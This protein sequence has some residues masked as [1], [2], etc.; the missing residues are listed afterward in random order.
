MDLVG[1][2]GLFYTAHLIID[3]HPAQHQ[4]P[5]YAGGD[6]FSPLRDGHLPKYART[7]Y[8]FYSL[9]GNPPAGNDCIAPVLKEELYLMP[10]FFLN[11]ASWS[12]R[13]DNSPVERAKIDLVIS[14]TYFAEPL[15][16]LSRL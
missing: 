6:G 7:E 16:V 12:S 14:P 11:R 2:T 8:L 4:L 1:V 9:P 15:G 13:P 10:S 3:H 5:G